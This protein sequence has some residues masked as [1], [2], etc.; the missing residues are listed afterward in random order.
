[1]VTLGITFLILDG[2]ATSHIPPTM[3]IGHAN[4]T[5]INW[6]VLLIS[7]RHALR[8]VPVTGHIDFGSRVLPIDERRLKVM[9][10]TAIFSSLEV[11]NETRGRIKGETGGGHDAVR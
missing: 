6:P 2:R 4:C 9:S 1:V 3:V 7:F 8:D 11:E 5:E 10:L